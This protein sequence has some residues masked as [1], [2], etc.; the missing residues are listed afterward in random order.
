MTL[1]ELNYFLFHLIHTDGA[2]HD[3]FL[4]PA[5]FF[6]HYLTTLIIIMLLGAAII[7]RHPYHLLF[8][9]ALVITLFASAIGNLCDDYLYLPRPFT[10]GI[11]IPLID[12][13]ANNSFPS[14]HMLVISTIALSYLFSAQYKLGIALMFC[15]LMVGWSRIYL[16]VHFPYDIIGAIIVALSLNMLFYYLMPVLL[17]LNSL[18]KF[19]FLSRIK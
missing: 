11:G 15:A 17:R 19:S 1:S 2:N 5:L 9:K 3:L 12:H 10:L 8:L 13:D 18:R 14:S 7:F 4:Q 16:G 6:S